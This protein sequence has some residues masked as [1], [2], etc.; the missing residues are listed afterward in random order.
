MDGTVLYHHCFNH[1]DTLTIEIEGIDP[2]IAAL[3]FDR[4]VIGREK[5]SSMEKKIQLTERLNLSV[6]VVILPSTGG[7]NSTRYLKT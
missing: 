3:T 2:A 6:Y 4:F 1:D 7:V 5:V